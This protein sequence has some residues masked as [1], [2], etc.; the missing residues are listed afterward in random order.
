MMKK[1]IYLVICAFFVS[2]VQDK[3]V[4]ETENHTNSI[5]TDFI[6]DI[7]SLE[8]VKGA[9]C[10]TQLKES[11]ENSASKEMT[12]SKENIE[13]YYDLISSG[14]KGLIIVENHTA[15]VIDNVQDCKNSGSWGAC[16]PMGIGYIKRGNLE[17]QEDYINNIIGT[18]D[19][20]KRVGFV[21]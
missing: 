5:A 3:K 17:E 15:V 11:A 1:I 2:C 12:L 19:S 16:M 21:F 13:E 6:N 10:I 9:D 8:S 18:P 14:A 20:Q 7:S 4:N